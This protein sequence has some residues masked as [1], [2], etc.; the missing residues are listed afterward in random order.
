MVHRNTGNEREAKRRKKKLVSFIPGRVVF[1]K[2]IVGSEKGIAKLQNLTT[3]LLF[4]LFFAKKNCFENP[5]F[6]SLSKR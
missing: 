3:F 5:S 4:Y 6:F 2:G 1:S